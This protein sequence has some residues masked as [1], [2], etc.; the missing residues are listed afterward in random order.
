MTVRYPARKFR[1]RYVAVTESHRFS[2][3]SPFDASPEVEK[4]E[5]K[6]HEELAG[7]T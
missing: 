2:M 4:D 6:F 1:C 7:S 3:C 5:T